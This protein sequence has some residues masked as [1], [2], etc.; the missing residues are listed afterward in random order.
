M[1]K[2]KI[3]QAAI[4]FALLSQPILAAPAP[5]AENIRLA[6]DVVPAPFG[7]E[8]V[9]TRYV[10]AE[11]TPIYVSPY[12]FPGTI[13]N[14]NLPRGAAVEVLAKVKDYDWVLVGRNGVG[15]GYLPI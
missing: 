7:Y 9:T 2:A 12:V 3:A 1:V 4:A 10:V 6:D 13:N 11:P 8:S 5:S 14:T 15:I